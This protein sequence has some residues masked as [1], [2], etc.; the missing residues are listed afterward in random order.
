MEAYCNHL[1]NE[2]KSLIF[3]DFCF[4]ANFLVQHCFSFFSHKN[5]VFSVFFFHFLRYLLIYLFIY[6]CFFGFSE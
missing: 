3:R 2:K 1:K 4:Y 6:L 5:S